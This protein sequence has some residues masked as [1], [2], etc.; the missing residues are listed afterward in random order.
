MGGGFGIPYK[1]QNDEKPLELE[2]FGQ[3]LAEILHDWS[4]RYNPDIQFMS[5][6]GRY[7][8]A[9]CGVLLGTVHAKKENGG[10]QYIGTDLGFNV[11]CVL[12]CTMPGMTLKYI[13]RTAKMKTWIGKQSP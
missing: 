6:P 7:V 13:L 3:Q 10:I 9:E 5:E 2:S 1:K 8:V 4:A 11:W 12:L